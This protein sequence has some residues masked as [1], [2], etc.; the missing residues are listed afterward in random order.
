[1][2][3]KELIPG[4]INDLSLYP[5]REWEGKGFS[6]EFLCLHSRVFSNQDK[7]MET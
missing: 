1:M 5:S 6:D 3:T 7:G 2:E 4:G